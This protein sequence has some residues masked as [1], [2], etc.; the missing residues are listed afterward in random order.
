MEFLHP[1]DLIWGALAAVIAAC[2]FVRFR[3]GRRDVSTMMLWRQVFARRR[4]WRRWQRPVSLAVQLFIFS[5]LVIG[6]CQPRWRSAWE[7]ARS[8][9]VVIDNS[10]SMNA[11]DVETSRLWQARQNARRLIDDLGPYEELAIVSAGGIVRVQSGFSGDAK[12]LVRALNEMRPTD[13]GNRVLEAVTVARQMLKGKRNP[14]VALL[15]DACLETACL[16]NIDQIAEEQ[17]VTI[18]IHNSRPSNIGI[19]RFEARPSAADPRLYDVFCEVQ[20]YGPQLAKCALEVGAETVSISVTPG[21]PVRRFYSVPAAEDRLL[22]AKLELAGLT[23]HLPADNQATVIL[24]SR[25]ALPVRVLGGAEPSEGDESYK[26]LLAALEQSPLVDVEFSENLDAE[27]DGIAVYPFR[28][29]EKL[30][31]GPVLAIAPQGDCD[32]WAESQLYEGTVVASQQDIATFPNLTLLRGVDLRG[33]VIDAVR[34]YLYRQQ[35]D[36]AIRWKGEH[37]VISAWDRPDG[38]VL[39]WHAPLDKT[40]FTL[41]DSFPH[42]IANAVRW[43][44]PRDEVY[45]PSFKTDDVIVAGDDQMFGPVDQVG[46]LSIGSNDDKAVVAVNLLSSRESDLRADADLRGEELPLSGLAGQGRLWMTVLLV[47]LI[48]LVVEW[49]LHQRKVLI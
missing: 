46:P 41:H 17:P 31:A 24:P 1:Q 28:I 32:L 3:R 18:V 38:R 9:V 23:D 13:G 16:E 5:L 14:Q 11:N 35:P 39:L 36:S 47:G 33:F 42:F 40:D 7:S 49:I 45:R 19:T 2:Y 8:I 34:Q 12:S 30:P 22:T 29:P 6:Y 10:A 4:P 25:S 21:S 20:N 44:S 26:R 43:L 37:A 27:F 48:L 15:T